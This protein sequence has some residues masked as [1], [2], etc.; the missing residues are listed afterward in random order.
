M[1][2]AQSFSIVK[3]TRRIKVWNLFYWSNTL[4]V[5]DYLFIHHQESETADTATGTCQTYT[6]GCLLAGKPASSRQYLLQ[7]VQS[8]IPD[9]GRKDR[10]KHVEFYSNKI[11]LRLWCIWLVLI[12]KYITMHSPMKGT[13]LFTRYL[14]TVCGLRQVFLRTLPFSLVSIT[15]P[16]LRTHFH[17]KL[18]APEL[19]F[20]KF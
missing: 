13:V 10:P 11:N 17:F 5:S 15:A 20:F 14:H 6:A 3:P 9:D 8:L 2:T 4:H 16:V 1:K 7:Y 19:F 12:Y 18:L